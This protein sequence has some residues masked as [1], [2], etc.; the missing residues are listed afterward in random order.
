MRWRRKLDSLP[1]VNDIN[2]LGGIYEVPANAKA[3]LIKVRDFVTPLHATLIAASRACV[4]LRRLAPRARMPA[5]VG[6]MDLRRGWRTL[7]PC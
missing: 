7:G 2:E 4:S 3:S 6:M 1:K 5:R